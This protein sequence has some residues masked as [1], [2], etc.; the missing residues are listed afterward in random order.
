MLDPRSRN[1]FETASSLSEFVQSYANQHA[2]ALKAI[3]VGALNRALEAL[4]SAATSGGRIYAIGNG[5]SA[6]ISDHL[7]CDFTKGTNATGHPVLAAHSLNA[8]IA[9]YSAVANDF[10][11]EQV[12]STQI[13]FFG[14]SKDVLIAI[15]SSG[16]SPNIIRA[17]EAA[18]EKGM[19]VIGLS[20]FGGGKLDKAA[21]ISLRVDV[22]N[23]GIVE[24]CHQSLMHIMAQVVAR[25]R[26]GA[27]SW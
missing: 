27:I 2:A 22:R 18:K 4:T 17:V 25:R 19:V 20:G 5:G 14:S 1:E 24:D 13:D 23:Y 7:C 9:L 16:N 11:F 10:S 3:D 8:N 12:F 15:S 21:D 6:A 26:D